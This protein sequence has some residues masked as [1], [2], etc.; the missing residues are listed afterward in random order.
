MQVTI[1]RGDVS[2]SFEWQVGEAGTLT[3]TVLLAARLADHAKLILKPSAPATSEVEKTKRLKGLVEDLVA[4][5]AATATAA[6][7][8][9]VAGRVER[10]K[11]MARLREHEDPE[12][13]RAAIVCCFADPWHVEHG[14]LGLGYICR[15]WGTVTSLAISGKNGAK[16][17]EDVKAWAEKH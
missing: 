2:V 5:Y 17:T 3:D 4:F 11:V 12:Q 15:N 16:K 8:A 13:I 7:V 6:K 9:V 14:V 1:K 10:A